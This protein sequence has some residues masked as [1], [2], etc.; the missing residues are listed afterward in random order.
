MSMDDSDHRDHPPSI[1]NEVVIRN[2][3]ASDA[4]RWEQLRC[5]LWPGAD[6]DHAAETAAFFAGT[7]AEPQAVLVAYLGLNMVGFSELSIRED[8]E[9]LVGKRAG[10]V[11]GLYVEPSSRG[12]GVARELLRASKLWTRN[13]SCEDFASD[14]AE[15]IVID[16]EFRRL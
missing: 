1:A 14:R 8:V 15:R 4:Q 11:E 7:L 2:L 5:E 6:D 12:Q 10:Y 3:V 16:Q 9:G 13:N